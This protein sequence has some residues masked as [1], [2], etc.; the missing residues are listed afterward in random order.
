MNQEAK[1]LGV[2]N[3]NAKNVY[4]NHMNLTSIPAFVFHM[5]RLEALDLT[6]NKLTSLPDEIGK[7]TTIEYLYIDD[8]A[9]TSVPSSIGKLTRLKEL[10][11]GRNQ[12]TSL[13][14]SM[15][16]LTR[17]TMVRLNNNK[18]SSL[19]ASIGDLARLR[20]LILNDN[21]LTRLPERFVTLVNLEDLYLHDNKLTSLPESFGNLVKLEYLNIGYNKL[22]TLPESIGNLKDLRY[23]DLTSNAFT[24][25]PNGLTRLSRTLSIVFNKKR[26]SV[27]GFLSVFKAPTKRNAVRINN[28]TNVFDGS[29]ME[30]RLSNVPMNKRAFINN[31]SNVKTNGTLRRVYNIDGLKGY[32]RGKMSGRLHGGTFTP[33]KITLLR[34]VPHV[35]NKSAYLRNIKNRL[36]NTY[37]KNMSGVIQ[38][39]KSALPSNVTKTD[40]NRLAKNVVCQRIAN[41][42]VNNRNRVINTYRS[43]GLLT[44]E[45]VNKYRRTLQ[46]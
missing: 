42:P 8:N 16:K 34:N 14:D 28:L 24:S 26:Y 9:L 2:S 36:T 43:W 6:G 12:L 5:P 22:T 38:A 35:V 21:A 15:G 23:L 27:E 7:L 41:T 18:V 13:P 45:D 32:M 31:A 39:T 40:V 33:N 3:M 44:N 19:P 30:A 29:I 1:N 10:G 46:K 20:K 37:V 4:L 17:L 11:L 25:L